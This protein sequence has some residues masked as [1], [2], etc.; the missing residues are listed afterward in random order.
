MRD[1][2]CAGEEDKLISGRT[3]KLNKDKS[4]FFLERHQ[5]NFNHRSEL[6]LDYD[7]LILKVL[8]NFVQL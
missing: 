4:E 6:E 1:Y 2:I 5:I 3:S 8:R 7:S